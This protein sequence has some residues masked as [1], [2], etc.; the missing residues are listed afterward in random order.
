[1]SQSV[2]TKIVELKFNNDN[3]K[4]KVD[5]TLQKLEQLNKDI[6]TVGSGKAFK[7]LAKD[8]N[9]VDVSS[10][11]KGVEEASKGFSKLEVVGIT[12]LANISN[13][14]VNFGKRIVSKLISPIT[15]GIM[16]GG[17]AR[18]KNIEQA[19]FQFEGLKIQKSDPT[20]SYYSEVMDAVLG[21]SYSYDVAAKAASQLAASN[22]GVTETTKKLASGSEVTA[23]VMTG[24][25][26]KA[27]LGIAGVASMTG[28]D[29]DSI[30][31]IFTRVAGQGR[32]MA[33]DLNSI[34]SRGLNAAAVLANSLGTTEDEV[35]DM[36][37]KGEISFEEFSNAMSEAYGSHAKDSTLMFQGAMD[38]VQAAL[39]RIGADFYGPALNAGRD[40]LNSITPIVDAIH[41]RLNPALEMSGNILEKA[42]KKV[43]QYS[44]MLA[45]LIERFPN[46][47]AS[48][49]D[50]IAEHMNAWTNI[51]DLYKRGNLK[52]AI[53]GLENYTKALEGMEGVGINGQQMIADY[54]GIDKD[55]ETLS[56]YLNMT[57]DAAEELVSTETVT[58]EQIGKVID[59]MIKD[60][61]LG[62][63]EFYKSFRK[64]WG[65]DPK[66]MNISG[67]TT[68]FDNYLRSV[69]RAEE[70]TKRFTKHVDVFFGLIRGAQSLI[71]SFKTILGG[72]ADIFVS[73]AGYLAP[74]G[75]LIIQR[76]DGTARFVVQTADFIATSESFGT[77]VESIIGIIDKLFSLINVGKI[78]EGI[79]YG[80]SKV[81]F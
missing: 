56:K 73:L 9:K 30:S 44:D 14:A 20:L 29:F 72:L 54:F 5:S 80:I 18:A 77:V 40:V 65:E 59:G 8:I 74:I 26:T 47:R 6:D 37:S 27:L 57:K 71:Q 43:S 63:N 17:L 12:A 11:S 55:A 1:M 4:D 75:P 61:T 66:L 46:D 22:I 58:S 69:I 38:D 34:A 19:T 52:E 36:V 78:A 16:Q 28:S 53:N 51:S 48:M 15:Q 60:G 62:F 13:A 23:K 50:W 35:R 70:P 2:D 21:T 39:A 49:S 10:V 31:Q 76:A 45:Y 64:L 24:D 67:I 68:E 81:L 25:M 32:V 7:N 79:L 3:F 42:S 33:N 41:N